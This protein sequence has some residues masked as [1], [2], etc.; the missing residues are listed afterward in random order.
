MFHSILKNKFK[1]LTN[2]FQAVFDS[3]NR[4]IANSIVFLG[5]DVLGQYYLAQN[6]AKAINCTG[7]KQ[8][9]CQCLNCNWIRENK[10]PAVMTISKI[11]NKSDE[12]KTVIS[13]KQTDF[14][15]NNLTNSSDY[16]RFFIFCD[17]QINPDFLQIN[18]LKSMDIQLPQENWHPIGLNRNTF[19][20]EAA[21]SLLKSIEETA[22]NTTF[23]FL[24][25]DKN[26]LIPTIISRSQCFYVPSTPPNPCA[27]SFLN[28]IMNGYPNLSKNDML[29]FSKRLIEIG[30]DKSYSTDFIIDCLQSYITDIIKA[31]IH[32]KAFLKKAYGHI[33]LLQEAKNQLNAYMKDSTV[34][35]NI[36]FEL[37]SG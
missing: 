4:N 37:F 32:N 11:D 10:H 5:L 6:L 9:D 17:A 23:I 34:L 22:S 29:N 7:T 12:S 33:F 31:N 2:Y 8:Y 28:E 25:A 20:D 35:D 1:Y 24:A 26:N 3:P 27:E 36:A 15:K 19:Q 14:V 30:K 18:E 21:N 16:H 13:L